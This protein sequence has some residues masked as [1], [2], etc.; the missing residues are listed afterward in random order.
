[1]ST[2]RRFWIEG[3]C[4]GLA[5]TFLLGS[6]PLH[7]ADINDGERCAP[8]GA[9][10]RQAGT[11]FICTKS[12]SAGVWKSKIASP[13][14]SAPQETFIMPNVIGMNLQLAQDLLQSKG[15]YVMDQEDF[16]RLGRIQIIDSNWR[17]CAQSP[18][19]GKKV[20]TT[21]LVTLSSVKL[22]EK[23]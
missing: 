22:A 17:V 12:G 18:A 23:C 21:S 8:V 2:K 1:M 14:K 11:D 5:I 15:S 10:F 6:A 7:A 16:K 3:V 20:S 9:T 4:A 19:S 13:T